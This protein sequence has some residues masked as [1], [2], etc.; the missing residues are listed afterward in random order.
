MR[1]WRVC[2]EGT[3]MKQ[4]RRFDILIW[5]LALVPLAAAALV[6]PRLPQTIPTHWGFDGTAD[7][8]GPSRRTG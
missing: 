5:V 1:G 4:S 8:Y 7:R 6:Y 3:A 2:W